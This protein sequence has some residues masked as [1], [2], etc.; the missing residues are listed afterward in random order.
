MIVD[1]FTDKAHFNSF[2]FSNV[3]TVA[4]RMLDNV[5]DITYWPLDEHKQEAMAK[6]RVGLGYT[7][8]AN[9]LLMMGL[10]YDSD[11]G[12]KLATR[13][14]WELRDAAYRASIA[15]AK[16]KGAFPLFD[17]EK[18]L[19]S[20]FCQRLDSDIREGI[21]KHGI[22]NS[23]LVSIAP[24]GTISLSFGDNCSSGI[25][26]SYDWFYQRDVR[27]QD[28][29]PKTV[30]VYDHAFRLYKKVMGWV[31][32]DDVACVKQLPDHW[33]SAQNIGAM[34]HVKMVEAIAPFIDSAISKTINVEENYPYDDFK[35]LYMESWKR[36][37]KGITTYR[38]NFRVASVLSVIK[39]EEKALDLD[40]ADPDRRIQLKEVPTPPMSSLRWQKRPRPAGGNP[41]WCTMID[42]PHGHSFAVFIGHIENGKSH[43]FEVW[44]NGAEQPRGLGALAKSLSMDMR[45]NDQDWLK[46]KLQS[47]MKLDTG[48]AFEL[49]LNEGAAG[50]PGLTAGFAKV[51]HERCDILG[52][53]D[54]DDATPVLDALMSPKEPKTGPD[55][56]LSWAVDIYN[57]ATGDDFLMGMKEL[58][59]PDGS[60][61]PYSVWLS[62]TYPRVL[63]GLCKSL[64]FDMRIVDPAWVGAKLA[65]LVDFPEPRGDFFARIPGQARQQNYPSTVAYMARLMIHRY[66]MLGVL[67]EEG[68]S[69]IPM[70]VMERSAIQEAPDAVD[71]RSVGAAEV[72]NLSAKICPDCGCYAVTKV[73]GCESCSECGYIGSCG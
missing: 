49:E 4:I 50:V 27:Q 39:T 10:K 66:A 68:Q 44:V 3:V 58:M 26:P 67:N 9:A 20:P 6:R 30:V 22:R 1:P 48:D 18:Y 8:L 73:N 12:R 17:A 14:T 55:G 56:T 57:P 41:A 53:F 16:E 60:R 72:R 19:A 13:I 42:H 43:P 63:D 54:S 15:L 36:G 37:I 21:R 65:Q 70:G 38:P 61:R 25:E 31:D 64:S 47:L 40:Q 35:D 11:E 34:D 62:G 29:S 7:G 51:V 2:K 45:S 33:V 32:L 28:V 23:H 46:T 59:L 24:T 5:L 71:Q 52:A 69:L